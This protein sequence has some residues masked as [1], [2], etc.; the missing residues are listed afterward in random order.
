MVAR[1]LYARPHGGR[2]DANELINLYPDDEAAQ[3]LSKQSLPLADFLNA[4]P[5]Y[6]PPRL[7]EHVLLHG[8]CHLKSLDRLNDKQYGELFNEK[9]VLKDMG[10]EFDEP[11]TGC[12]GMAG[13][14][15]FE[16]EHYEVSQ[17]V[18]EHGTLPAVRQAADETLILTDGFSCREQIEQ[19]AGRKTLHAAELAARCLGA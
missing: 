14:F 7:T 3:R 17:A 9:A 5:H 11:K 1:S 10:V 6:V 2:Y 15:G 16:A 8:H 18:G 4:L 19:G 13:A 12:C